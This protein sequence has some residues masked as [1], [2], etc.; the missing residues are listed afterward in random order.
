MQLPSFS[1]RLVLSVRYKTDSDL[2]H[3]LPNFSLHPWC[4][5][6]FA[7]P[8]SQPHLPPPEPELPELAWILPPVSTNERAGYNE[9]IRHCFRYEHSY[10]EKVC[11]ISTSAKTH[12]LTRYLQRNNLY[13]CRPLQLISSSSKGRLNLYLSISRVYGTT[14]FLLTRDYCLMTLFIDPIGV[15]HRCHKSGAAQV[16]RCHAETRGVTN[17]TWALSWMLSSD[18]LTSDTYETRRTGNY[19]SRSFTWSDYRK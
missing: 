9:H 12:V 8:A 13:K 15:H 4:E 16:T 19:E 18:T 14:I 7:E 1:A 17:V 11:E 2:V 3:K 10:K 6:N 5:P